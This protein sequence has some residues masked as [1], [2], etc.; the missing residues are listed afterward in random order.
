MNWGQQMDEATKLLNEVDFTVQFH[1][2]E[3]R[4]LKG[5]K[6]IKGFFE[7]E[8]KF[9]QIVEN[10]AGKV[11]AFINQLSQ[12]VALLDRSEA[13]VKNNPD[14]FPGLKQNI[15]A[16][17][18]NNLQ[19]TRQARRVIYSSKPEASFLRDLHKEDPNQVDSAYLYFVGQ[20]PSIGNR[21]QLLGTLRAY[22][23]D[24]QSESIIVKKSKDEKRT[25]GRLRSEW[26]E[27]R[28]N[29]ISEHESFIEQQEQWKEEFETKVNTWQAEKEEGVTQLEEL[30]G[31][32][33]HLEAPV[34]YWEN[35]ATKYTSSARNWLWVTIGL[36]AISIL[37]LL[38]VL[39][40]MP[41]AFTKSLFKG[42]PMAI[43]GIIIFASIISFAAY[44]IHIVVKIMLS[45]YH[46]VR[47]S[48]ERAQLTHVYLALIK[49]E[50]ID[51][52]D[53]QI[54]LQALFSRADTGLLKEDSSPTMPNY[55]SGLMSTF[56][57]GSG[58]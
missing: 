55:L 19:Q 7:K 2:G 31:E 17:L 23:F 52:E 45:N 12:A 15:L 14:Q 13:Q 53:R 44:L 5:T 54:V 32:K 38:A 26:D 36:V 29:L 21:S 27:T 57:P 51:K 16:E 37:I 33:L 11:Q 8:L 6:T 47:D 34:Q 39:Y 20:N 1:D 18:E 28:T 22:E 58:R 25:L 56:K 3:Q 43:R 4:E 42:D 50:A 35:R 40:E 48:E 41:E 10:P 46:L 49:N 9:W 30:Y 24:R